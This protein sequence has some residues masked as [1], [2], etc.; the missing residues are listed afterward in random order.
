VET[1]AESASRTLVSK[2]LSQILGLRGSAME[3]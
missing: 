3:S 2:T 1:S